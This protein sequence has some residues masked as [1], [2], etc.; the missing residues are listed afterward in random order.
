M[1]TRTDP[2]AKFSTSGGANNLAPAGSAF[3]QQPDQQAPQG[4]STLGQVAGGLHDQWNSFIDHPESR[5]GLMQFAVNMLSGKGFGESVG[6]GAEAM[7]R[8]VTAQLGQEKEEEEA[9]R[10][11]RETGAYETTAQAALI[12][13]Q[14]GDPSDRYYNQRILADQIAAKNMRADK[15]NAW[16]NKESTGLDD[17]YAEYMKQ[18]YPGVAKKDLI[19]PAP[20]S[21]AAQARDELMDRIGGRP[22]FAGGGAPRSQTATPPRPKS[23]PDAVLMDVN[24]TPVWYDPKTKRPAQ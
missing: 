12:R 19:N 14:R 6:A 1:D 7:G 17:P 21:L 15:F 11:E 13:A 4:Q 8:N 18:K 20:G 5:A 3:D 9:A 23:V 24:G 2:N 16:L 10:K 22:E